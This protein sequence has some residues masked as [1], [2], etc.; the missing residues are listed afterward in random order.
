MVK[1]IA[2]TEEQYDEICELDIN[3][4]EQ[5]MQVIR[6]VIIRT[7]QIEIRDKCAMNMKNIN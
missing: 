7:K 5:Q 3:D 4:E 1:R 2:L 6:S